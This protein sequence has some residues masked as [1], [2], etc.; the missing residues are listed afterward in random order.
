MSKYLMNHNASLNELQFTLLGDALGDD[1]AKM[2]DI[3]ME[4]GLD[5]VSQGF[6]IWDIDDNLELYS[7]K[8]RE[9]LGYD[10]EL[11]FPSNPD[12]WQKA[13]D[14]KYLPGVMR[15]FEKHVESRGKEPYIQRVVYNKKNGG[16]VPVLCH[17]KVVV[18]SEDDK[19]LVMI[20]V[21]MTFDGLYKV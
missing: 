12:S 13:I 5:N 2:F 7:P 11:D 20:G 19:P 18:W 4:T 8:F 3:L 17:G 16:K 9:I 1:I 21:H 14:Q 6:W 10:G 15:T